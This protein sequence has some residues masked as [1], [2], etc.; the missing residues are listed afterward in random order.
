MSLVT[1][2]NLSKTFRRG[3]PDEVHAVSDVGFEIHEGQTLGLVGES[4]SGK[5]TVGRLLLRLIEADEGDIEIRG[6]SLRSLKPEALRRQRRDMQMVFQEPYQSLSPRMTIGEIVGEPLLVHRPELSRNERLEKVEAVLDA[7]GLD[8]RLLNSRP[9]MLSGGQQQRVG[10]AR[11]II[12]DPA[13]I[14][15]DEPTSSLDLSVQ[16][17]I[18]RLLEGLKS[19]LSTAFLYISHDLATVEY[20]ADVV[21]VMHLGKVCEMGP[22]DEVLTN[23]S[24]SYTKSLLDASLEVF[25]V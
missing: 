1:V 2:R 6:V 5:S 25:D 18:L 3:R 20:L 15:F 21:A 7:V 8:Q 24:N 4:G 11:A 17:Q 22:T 10:I 9:R 16:A 12:T 19:R 13:L 23:P 14:V